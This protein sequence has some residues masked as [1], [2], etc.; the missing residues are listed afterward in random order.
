MATGATIDMQAITE[1]TACM[2]KRRAQY[3]IR[4]VPQRVDMVL[5]ESAVKDRKSLNEAAI[6]A[7]TRGLGIA[8]EEVRHHDLDDLAGTWV[9]DPAFDQ[10]IRDMDRIDPELWK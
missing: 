8:G 3:T 4:D 6:E 2:K 7:M 5:R 10:A 9:D 1:Y